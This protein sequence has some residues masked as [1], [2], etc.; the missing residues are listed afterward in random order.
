MAP[1][2]S[3][4]DRSAKTGKT[5]LVVDDSATMRMSIE[6]S[7]S[8]AGYRVVKAEHGGAALALLKDGLRPDLVLTDIVMP[9]VDGL[10][11]IREARRLLRFTPI[12]AL[13]TQNQREMRD[14]GK[15]AGATAWLLKPTGGHD[16]VAVVDKFLGQP[17]GAAP[18]PA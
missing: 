17:A 3:S 12:I 8:L 6:M 1:A 16:L 5:V 14:Q 18:R 7:L 10:S 13:T 4:S 9:N 11:L 2:S 15:A